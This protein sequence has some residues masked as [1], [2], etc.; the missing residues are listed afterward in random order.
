LPVTKNIKVIRLLMLFIPVMFCNIANAQV[1]TS[2]SEALTLTDEFINNPFRDPDI[3]YLEADSLINDEN[4]GVL[5]ASWK[6][7]SN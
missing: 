3:I 1:N 6:R 4:N 7:S 5:I 2:A